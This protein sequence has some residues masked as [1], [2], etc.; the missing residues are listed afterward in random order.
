MV[1]TKSLPSLVLLL[2]QLSPWIPGGEGDPWWDAGWAARRLIE[3]QPTGAGVPG[4]ET[5]VVEFRTMG[6]LAPNGADVRLVADGQLAPFKVMYAG[7]DDRCVVAFRMPRGAKRHW[8]Y[9]G[10]PKAAKAGGNWE[11]ERGLWLETRRFNGGQCETW[12]QMKQ[13]VARSGP[14]FGAGP[15]RMVFQGCN[16][17]AGTQR[18][19]SIYRGWLV[20]S[21]DGEYRFSTS[22]KDASFVFLDGKPLVSHPGWH[23]PD[24][25]A[26]FVGK[27]TSPKGAKLFEYYHVTG[28]PEGMAGAYWQ[29]PSGRRFAPIPP[30]A[31]TPVAYGRA[32]P[33]ELRGEA[34]ADFDAGLVSEAY[35]GERPLLRYRFVL[36]SPSGGR[37]VT[38]DFG[39]GQNGAGPEVTHVFFRE[40]LFSVSVKVPVGTRAVQ[41]ASRVSVHVDYARQTEQQ[42]DDPRELLDQALRYR[43][44]ALDTAS[45]E[46]ASAFYFLTEN[47]DGQMAAARALLARQGISD[48]LYFEQVMRLQLLM[49][50]HKKDP[51]AAMSLLNAA[52]Q[53]LK[54][55]K[56]MRAKVLREIGDV[57]YFHKRDLDRA[58]LE[59]DKVVGRYSGL[60]DHIVRVT[61]IRIGD[62]MRERGNAEKAAANYAEAEKLRLDKWAPDQVPVRM[63]VLIHA[64][65]DFLRRGDAA[66]ARKWVEIWEWEFPL[67]RLRG[68]SSV[69]RARIALLE[70]NAAEAKQQLESLVRVNPE[71][72][73]IGVALF[74]LA[75]MALSEKDAAKAKS[76]LNEL[77]EKHPDSE[78]VPDAEAKLKEIEKGERQQEKKAAKAEKSSLKTPAKKAER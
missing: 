29:P 67:E 63:G 37:D 13:L 7:A 53:R 77:I 50:E 26:R 57:Y 8:L 32:G 56:N 16:L 69:L 34:A 64:T 54:N 22:S 74:M 41:G 5:G 76:L 59:Y 62:I 38:W 6:R 1:P 33:L 10:N 73:Y 25:R 46:A 28:G 78:C 47:K 75:E 35:V 2:L 70:K 42:K 48:A 66:E 43:F 61:K 4:T 49:R 44:D 58:L 40:A 9:Y 52:E 71:S 51:D 55:D 68:Q 17:F 27:L 20:C 23:P 19:V 3:V 11:P 24:G 30:E 18:Y 12:E 14:A 36:R 65:E 72:Q 45:L 15:V 21:E 60:E 31:F 39:D